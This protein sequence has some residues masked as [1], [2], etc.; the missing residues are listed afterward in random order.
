MAALRSVS[1]DRYDEDESPPAGD[2]VR[3]THDPESWAIRAA[4]LSTLVF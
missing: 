3:I 1:R 2:R 4:I